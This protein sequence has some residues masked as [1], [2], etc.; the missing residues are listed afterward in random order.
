MQKQLGLPPELMRHTARLLLLV[1][2]VTTLGPALHGVHDT[3]CDPVVVIHDES[4]H[5]FAAASSSDNEVAPGEHCLACHFLRTSRGPVSWEPNGLHT[6]AS[7]NLL[8]H[9]DGQLVAAPTAS[10]Q[11]ARA[12]PAFA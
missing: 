9:S 7:G 12:P 2:S 4:Q 3:D 6:L 11:P 8:Y 10:P 5:H 1:L